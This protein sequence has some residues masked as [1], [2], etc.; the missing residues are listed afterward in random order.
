[1]M[2]K[3][4]IKPLR[5]NP[6]EE[7]DL[8]LAV[9]ESIKLWA[10]LTRFGCKKDKLHNY[11]E[12]VKTYKADCPLCQYHKY[13]NKEFCRDGCILYKLERKHCC[14]TGTAYTRWCAASNESN[15]KRLAATIT[16]MLIGWYKENYG[17]NFNP[18]EE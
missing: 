4:T 2:S 13:Q 15:R 9:E 7:M 3:R 14:G 18:Y 10:M 17:S 11:K 8:K 16:R 6:G 5:K 12:V 1:M